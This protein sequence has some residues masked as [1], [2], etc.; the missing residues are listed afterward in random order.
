[1][2]DGIQ[3]KLDYVIEFNKNTYDASNVIEISKYLETLH[4]LTIQIMERL[5]FITVLTR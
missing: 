4:L 2:S 1:M 3:E 5:I